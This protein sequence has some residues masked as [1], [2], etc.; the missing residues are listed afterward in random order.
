MGTVTAL[1][2][3]LS[4]ALIGAGIWLVLRD[5]RL[6]QARRAAAQAAE[7]SLTG[8]VAD[9]PTPPPTA[10]GDLA[11]EVPPLQGIR[12][13]GPLGADVMAALRAVNG[14]FAPAGISL[15]PDISQTPA[16]E[17]DPQILVATLLAGD[18]RVGDLRIARDGE[19]VEITASSLAP[20]AEGV[21][22]SRRLSREEI[23]IPALAEAMAACAWP[24]AT[25]VWSPE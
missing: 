22:R 19:D 20:H 9:H 14:A 16:A 1:L 11:Q 15:V 6:T 13:P 25:A 3:V 17:R 8:A 4:C 21:V 24:V 5:T 23:S 2:A 18:R 10:N 7:P 12:L